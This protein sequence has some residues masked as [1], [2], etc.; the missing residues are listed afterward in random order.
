M[1][2]NL[3]LASLLVCL[4]PSPAPRAAEIE[5]YPK[6]YTLKLGEQIHY[7][8]IGHDADGRPRFLEQITPF[9]FGTS[10][11]DALSLDNED[12]RFTGRSPGMAEVLVKTRDGAPARFSI[13]VA[14]ERFRPIE[15]VRAEDGPPFHSARTIMV[16]HANRD[17]FDHTRV[18]KSG[19]DRV[20]R[21]AKAKGDNVVFLMSPQ[22][23][24]WYTSDRAPSL[25]IESD[26]GEHDLVVTSD[27]I[28]FVG[29]NFSWCL[30]ESVKS[31]LISF[32]S[33]SGSDLC[34]VF[35][36]D[37]IYDG[38]PGRGYPY[39]M[40]TL[41]SLFETQPDSAATFERVVTPFL[42]KLQSSLAEAQTSSKVT[43]RGAASNL[44]TAGVIVEFNGDIV[45][46]HQL[47]SSER[48]LRFVFQSSR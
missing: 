9:E 22:Y 36:L 3:A 31:S 6:Y 15:S 23:P 26:T 18:A 17:G 27:E 1:R 40:V 43:E 19:I 13:Q 44:K 29:G 38:D 28:V 16:T 11:P 4:I 10:D 33:G 42:E 32:A 35:P 25:A 41:A 14:S 45:R 30:L 12:G 39:P 48:V 24:N 34:L 46:E 2:S 5:L 7:T 8:A 20:V 47:E 21:D 37:A